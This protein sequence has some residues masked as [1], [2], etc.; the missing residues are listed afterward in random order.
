MTLAEET[1]QGGPL[2]PSTNSQWDVLMWLADMR[3]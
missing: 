2:H 3:H 1:A